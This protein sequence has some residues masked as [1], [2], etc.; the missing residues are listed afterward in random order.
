MSGRYFLDTNILVRS[1]DARHPAKQRKAQALIDEALSENTGF[2]ST[3]VVQEFLNV[4]LKKFDKPLTTHECRQYLDQVLT[5]LCDLFPSIPLYRRA[6][7]LRDDA[8]VGF[9]DAL[10]IASA[11]LGGGAKFLYTEDLQHG[12]KI[13]GLTIQ[14]P[15][16]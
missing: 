13:T 1:F 2:I 4:A 7:D 9:Y 12:R 16:I 14:N 8:G 6:L 3:Q 10:I 15:F 11:S 5:P